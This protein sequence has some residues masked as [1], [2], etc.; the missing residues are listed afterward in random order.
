MSPFLIL[1]LGCALSLG[2]CATHH[3]H[4]DDHAKAK[5]P[6]PPV[7]PSTVVNL[8]AAPKP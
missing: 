1:A 4:K 3:P 7:T 5:F 2:A 8:P 6:A